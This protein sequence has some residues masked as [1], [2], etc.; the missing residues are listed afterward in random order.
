MT[1]LTTLLEKNA[2]IN[3]KT[4]NFSDQ[5]AIDQNLKLGKNDKPEKIALLKAYQRILRLTDSKKTAEALCNKSLHSVFQITEMAKQ[6]FIE[7]HAQDC[8]PQDGRTAQQEAALVY[9][10]A[11]ARKMQLVQTYI[12]IH[13]HNSA[14]YKTAR[15][16]NLSAA[17]AKN[18]NRV[19]SYEDFF[20]GLDFCTCP[21]CR[22]IFSPA[23]YFVDLMQ[24]QGKYITPESGKDQ[25]LLLKTRRP[26]LWTTELSCKNTNTLVPTITI[27]NEVL[28]Q[29]IGKKTENGEELNEAV[30]PFNL[31][32][33]LPLTETNFYLKQQ[34]TTLEQLWTLL[35]SGKNDV[36]A[37]NIQLAAIGLS[38]AQ[39]K[40]YSTT[41]ADVTG[42]ASYYGLNISTETDLIKALSPVEKF[43]QQTGLTYV[44]LRE[45]VYQGLSEQQFK[46]NSYKIPKTF[47]MNAG[48]GNPI[49]ISANGEE[50]VDLSIDR[51]DRL[52]RF[53]RLAQALNWSFSDLNWAL[54]TAGTI[55]GKTE[56]IL[57]DSVLPFLS[58]VKATLDANPKMTMNELCALQAYL[59]DTPTKDQK[60]FLDQVFFNDN[61]PNRD[62]LELQYK[63]N[64]TWNV[65]R[66]DV[67]TVE[68]SL[69]KN[70]P[71]PYQLPTSI[72]A[73]L[74]DPTD[75]NTVYF[76]KDE[77]F[78]TC[79]WRERTIIGLPQKIVDVFKSLSNT[80]ISRIT[81][82][83]NINS[84]EFYLFVGE[85]YYRLKWTN[86]TAINGNYPKRVKDIEGLGVNAVA[87]VQ[88]ALF[89]KKDSKTDYIYLFDSEKY[90]RKPIIGDCVEGYPKDI[91]EYWPG[92]PNDLDAAIQDP[93]EP[94]DFGYFFKGN[95]CFKYKYLPGWEKVTEI[96]YHVL[97]EFYHP[98]D[99][100]VAYKIQSAL[101]AALKISVDDL[102][103]TAEKMLSV[104]GIKNRGLTINAGNLATFYRCSNLSKLCGLPFKEIAVALSLPGA[105]A[106]AIKIIT[107][108]LSSNQ[109]LQVV[110]EWLT[111][112]AK[113][114]KSGSFTSYGLQYLL[115]GQSGLASIQNQVL[116][117]DALVNFYRDFQQS[118]SDCFITEEKLNEALNNYVEYNQYSKKTQEYVFANT[119]EIS[120]DEAK[121][122]EVVKSIFPK[123]FAAFES[124]PYQNSIEKLIAVVDA[125]YKN[126]TIK[127]KTQENFIKA[128]K[129][130]FEEAMVLRDLS[131]SIWGKITDSNKD[132]KV[133]CVYIPIEIEKGMVTRSMEG[134]AEDFRIAIEPLLFLSQLPMEKTGNSHV[135]PTLLRE[136]AST[137]EDA[138]AAFYETQ[139][140]VFLT[141]LSELYN[142]SSEIFAPIIRHVP[143]YPESKSS[144][145]PLTLPD[146]IALKGS[147][148]PDENLKTALRN[149]QVYAT[150]VEI[151]S[152][153]G[154]ETRNIV[155]QPGVYG[156]E[157]KE[158]EIQTSPFL[159]TLENLL[160]ITRLKG[161]VLALAD[162]QNHLLNYF[163]NVPHDKEDEAATLLHTLTQWNKEQIKFLFKNLWEAI[164]AKTKNNKG[165][166]NTLKHWDTVEG[167]YIITQWFAAAEALNLDVT[168]L[169]QIY[170]IS[171][172]NQ[173]ETSYSVY[174]QITAD[175]W[176][177]LAIRFE[178][179]EE[180]LKAVKAAVQIQTRNAL[181]PY[182]LYYLRNTSGID[183]IYNYRDLSNY[184]LIDVEVGSEVETSRIGSAI[185]TVQLYVH[186]CL[187]N[188]EKDVMVLDELEEWWEW[189]AN[190]RVWEANRK[191]FLYPENYIEPELRKDKTPLFTELETNLQS[192][193]LKNPADVEAV[194]NTYMDGFAEVA[195]LEIIGSAGYDYT[196]EVHTGS[197]EGGKSITTE[198]CTKT[199]C[200][201]GRSPEQPDSYYYRLVLFLKENPAIEQYTP[202][203]WEPWYT[204]N[205]GIQTTN[206]VKPLFAFGKWFITWVE[207]LQTGSKKVGDEEM[208]TYTA[209]CKLSYLN[210]NKEWVTPQSLGKVD[211]GIYL[212][213]FDKDIETTV[214]QIDA[215]EA[216]IAYLE[217]L[218]AE[219]EAKFTE[220]KDKDHPKDPTVSIFQNYINDTL[221]SQLK[222]QNE[223]LYDIQSEIVERNDQ[224]KKW[225]CYP[226]YM[227]SI[228]LLIVTYGEKLEDVGSTHAFEYGKSG[229]TKDLKLAARFA[230]PVQLYE[231]SPLNSKMAVGEDD[232]FD[233]Q[234]WM[235]F[236]SIKADFDSKEANTFS[237]WTYFSKAP[238]SNQE[239]VFTIDFLEGGSFSL[240]TGEKE[241]S[242]EFQF[243]KALSVE[244]ID[245]SQK[246]TEQT[247]FGWNSVCGS[248]YFY[249]VNSNL[250]IGSSTQT[251]R[252]IQFDG[253]VLY[254]AVNGK[255]V[256][257]FELCE[258]KKTLLI[259]SHE[260][261]NS[262]GSSVALINLGNRLY[263]FWIELIG[264]ETSGKTCFSE[265]NVSKG[266]FDTVKYVKMAGTEIKLS[267]LPGIAS[268]N[269]G[270]NPIIY[271]SWKPNA[272]GQSNCNLAELDLIT[273]TL[274]NS[275]VLKNSNDK[276]IECTNCP[277]LFFIED[278]LYL[279]IALYNG[280]EFWRYGIDRKMVLCEVSNDGKGL[281]FSKGQPPFLVIDSIVLF[282][283]S[284]NLYSLEF[285]GKLAQVEYK[286]SVYLYNT[287]DFVCPLFINNAIVLIEKNKQG[288]GY[289]ST[290]LFQFTLFLNNRYA[291]SLI[292]NSTLAGNRS[293]KF[294]LSIGASLDQKAFFNGY[295]Q[296]VQIFKSYAIST[297]KEYFKSG[298][299][300]LTR[301]Y[302]NAV[303]DSAGVINNLNTY[304][305]TTIEPSSIVINEPGWQVCNSKGI[306]FL[307]GLQLAKEKN[308]ILSCYRLNTTAVEDLSQTL[309]MQ[310]IPG[311]FSIAS[312][313]SP[314]IP[315]AVLNPNQTKIPE[316]TWPTNTIDFGNSAMSQY[317]WEIFFF[318]P[319]LIARSLQN[320]HHSDAAKNWFEYIFNPTINKANW[321]LQLTEEKS[322]ENDK[323]WRFV[324]LRA[325]YNARL[326]E[327][328]NETWS[329]EVEKDTSN[330]AQLY[331]YHNDPFDPQAIAMLRPIAYQK[332]I[333][334]HYIDNLVKWGDKLFRQYT[335]ESITEASMIYM[336]AY[337]L[338]GNEPMDLGACPLPKDENYGEILE[339]P[340]NNEFLIGLEQNLV[341]P[342]GISHLTTAPINYIPDLY[343]G[344][345]ENELFLS[346]WDTVKERLYFIRHG[347]NIDGIRQKLALFQPAIDPAKLVEQIA[348]G[349]SISDALTNLQATIPYYRFAVMIQLAKNTT[350]TVMQFGQSLLA[351][352]EKK[353]AE[354]LS[355]MY[356]QNQL[357]LLQQTTAGKQAQVDSISETLES[358]K[359]S[360]ESAE[361]RYTYYEELIDKGLSGEEEKQLSLLTGTI[362]ETGIG[363]VS[364][365]IAIG[366]YMAPT[367]F[368]L[369]N[370]AFNPGASFSET[371]AV[372]D[373]AGNILS[374]NSSIIGTKG[375]FDRRREEWEFQKKTAEKDK[376]QLEHQILS[377]KY[378]KEAAVEEVKLLKK[379]IDQEQKVQQFM[380]NKF[381][382][383]QLYQW[384]AGKLAA[385]YFQ[386]Y[387]MAYDMSLQA[388]QAWNF[389]K[390]NDQSFIK[391]AYW[392]GLYQGLLAGEALLTNLMQM[393]NSYMLQN[394]RR[395]EIQK[396]ISLKMID[397]TALQNLI[398][399]GECLF[400]FTE[401]LFNY[402]YPGHYCRQI[403]SLSIS[404]PTLIGP[405]QNI[406][407]T[408]TQLSN[409][410]ILKPSKELVDKVKE[411]TDDKEIR[412]NVQVN[413]QIALSQ[414]IN[415]S[416]MFTLNFNDERYL[417]FE[418]TGAVSSWKLVM[419]TDDNLEVV[420]DNLTDVIF[421]LNYTALQ[422][423]A[424]FEKEVRGDRPEGK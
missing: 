417:P 255:K 145:R 210:F 333:V 337:D 119:S 373:A 79:K 47:F 125:F 313:L 100:A 222:D 73:A 259:A 92:L 284:G 108:P 295:M 94:A 302:E 353:D 207:C 140:N 13:Q 241:R 306:E 106:D 146:L 41:V 420:F 265:I 192:S 272:A 331:A 311:L 113:L 174:Q 150:L 8:E 232:F 199:F 402:D 154:A 288:S 159:L 114:V 122:V 166:D 415:D 280:V 293:K 138:I 249:E 61:V 283:A 22:T 292:F 81:A 158:G 24:T 131:K 42:L 269:D 82:A 414:G 330:A 341:K 70:L 319:F 112:Y 340:H 77:W 139:Q 225:E 382:N 318:M 26:D 126:E 4:F 399:N 377:T 368:G 235:D 89:R 196:S 324:G 18:F 48:A 418:G 44:Q 383:K 109:K 110:L 171:D 287:Y 240:T 405:Y 299:T 271:F 169:W 95:A 360:L 128:T 120:T 161:L 392:D 213:K 233:Y 103:Y 239:P 247:S 325:Y 375:S 245:G 374:T 101:V 16:D 118:I 58:W 254:S 40:L 105:P 413:Q 230:G 115:T 133:Y 64:G 244:G 165:E 286:A 304:F 276:E 379:N 31:P 57:D 266:K 121:I 317:Y 215:T 275:F 71:N 334:M 137:V 352:L 367:V 214:S 236:K 396:T 88:A 51:L 354:Q 423:S 359:Y 339:K 348:S 198:E 401:T 136:L 144:F 60:S 300:Q 28:T 385:Q 308:T 148:K 197:V 347:L 52:N 393:E 37:H 141:E 91:S 15:F 25:K 36:Q 365:T 96:N 191:V 386:C 9:D 53:I 309:Y 74:N 387:Q 34:E 98:N 46:E 5:A 296:D 168:S 212:S 256:E 130:S 17:T 376:Q 384:M 273:G 395:L 14:H 32:Y 186:R 177:G 268:A 43:L 54:M 263:A 326:K 21:E 409:T 251:I 322:D 270:N 316:S 424:A 180:K 323:Y 66:M 358:L 155:H 390:G 349:A 183:G 279:S 412:K 303:L 204:I 63:T 421:Q 226:S 135:N 201:V 217:S 351:V 332:T 228:E 62:V 184:L 23:A 378:Q 20:G 223:L 152:L 407:A 227:N 194:L 361:E 67:G 157:Y 403:V 90:S 93:N 156:I 285:I 55:L 335:V 408:L 50:L 65:P 68:V 6:V 160:S 76:F 206:P 291:S 371:G 314:E 10:K 243:S 35:S 12:G 242:L 297:C 260:I 289:Q 193:D 370:G 2:A 342:S 298:K 163:E 312:Q 301:G 391:G 343:F 11:L 86:K 49:T 56:A 29:S 267:T 164:P 224:L 221:I 151:L 246:I 258:D 143:A 178:K 211:L 190:Y 167:I 372:A 69:D 142:L 111:N 176:G 195:N 185:S 1:T 262:F 219:L 290:Q 250:G 310:G 75:L 411:G 205:L 38:A 336:M 216:S 394:K 218:I 170:I 305:T 346:Y 173:D 355:L 422:G 85:N 127:N 124:N 257:I 45:L 83:A 278:R 78:Y 72:D 102:I 400:N 345:P 200:L 238:A 366:A 398:H 202:V 117:D 189:M 107:T 188:L 231:N 237:S 181:A 350:Q 27:V 362:A 147:D 30:Y 59:K 19:P 129:L 410:T 33:N 277:G 281:N 123:E 220:K 320:Q 397:A 261:T 229:V 404:F 208:P 116:G 132:N 321:D 344:L 338:L 3:L 328:L 357:T 87:N 39:W 274:S 363:M 294:S 175:L 162:T 97:A 356:N 282:P 209:E 99:P 234:Y 327:E 153:S 203:K 369:A 149:L 84:E 104:Q 248:L 182:A 419:N 329:E 381:T 315:F 179:E 307:S 364:K 80:K 416:G 389:E 7:K 252:F 134:M 406:H 187:N 253:M 172:K 264:K 388:Q 380:K